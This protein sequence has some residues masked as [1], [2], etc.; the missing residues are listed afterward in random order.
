MIELTQLIASLRAGELALSDYLDYLEARFQEVEPLVTMTTKFVHF[1]PGPTR[2]PHNPAHTP[3]G[4]SSGSA[5]AGAAGL[6]P[7]ALGTQTIGSAIRPASFDG[8]AARRALV[9]R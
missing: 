7:L 1:A 4:Y 5:A 8:L 3:G 9:R 2:S 6:C